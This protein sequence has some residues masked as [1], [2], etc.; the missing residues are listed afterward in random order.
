MQGPDDLE[1]ARSAFINEH[2]AREQERAAQYRPYVPKNNSIAQF[3]RHTGEL[4]EHKREIARRA[5]RNK[6]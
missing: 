2:I 4:H 6:N 3:N 1:K 5:R